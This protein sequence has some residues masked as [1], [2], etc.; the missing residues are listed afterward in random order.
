MTKIIAECGLGHMGDP[1]R[2]MSLSAA[3]LAAGADY[4]KWQLLL[5]PYR[6]AIGRGMTHSRAEHWAREIPRLAP[7]EWREVMGK[8]P[9]QQRM[10]SVFSPLD[11]MT[12]P[13]LPVD[14]LKIGHAEGIGTLSLFAQSVASELWITD[15]GQRALRGIHRMMCVPKYPASPEEGMSVLYLVRAYGG[16][17]GY[18]DHVPDLTCALRAI[19]EE[20][21]YLEVHVHAD[22]C[23]GCPDHAVSKTMTELMALCKEAHK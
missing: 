13:S 15:N 2:A 17:C 18:S 19:E 14:L 11:V 8:I 9:R 20:S 7:D 4:V 21:P 1:K 16:E 10:V 12:A 3:A 22:D 23:R 5:D 6:T